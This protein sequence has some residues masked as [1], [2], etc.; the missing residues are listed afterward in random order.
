MER[1][2]LIQQIYARLASLEDQ[3]EEARLAERDCSSL[4]EEMKHLRI[5]LQNVMN[6]PCP[7]IK[8]G[9]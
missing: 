7:I 8:D 4:D 3:R 1:L 2:K 6:S 5:K 9:N